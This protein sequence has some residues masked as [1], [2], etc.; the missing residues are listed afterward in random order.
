MELKDILKEINE[1]WIET[2]E[3]FDIEGDLDVIIKDDGK[4][5]KRKRI[6]L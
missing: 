1:A 6:K 3:H 5:F 4:E 2:K